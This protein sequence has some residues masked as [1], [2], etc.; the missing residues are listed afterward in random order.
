MLLLYSL[1][2]T[3]QLSQLLHR[4]SRRIPREGVL[5][6][7]CCQLD[8]TTGHGGSC[9]Q[10]LRGVMTLR[11]SVLHLWVSFKHPW[12]SGGPQ[13][14]HKRQIL[15]SFQ[16]QAQVLSAS[17]PVHVGGCMQRQK[18]RKHW[19]SCT[20]RNLR[21]V[22]ERTRSIVTVNGCHGGCVELVS[23]ADQN[24]RSLGSGPGGE[25]TNDGAVALDRRIVILQF[26]K[27]VTLFLGSAGC[28]EQ[29]LTKCGEFICRG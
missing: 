21:P 11:R 29:V 14:K 7:R 1:H 24:N 23:T 28:L 2:F 19:E 12:I 8:K 10:V 22:A 25:P 26:E 18:L 6:I 4:C 20:R 5:N 13:T 27:L 17:S 16:M 15:D 9:S 3:F